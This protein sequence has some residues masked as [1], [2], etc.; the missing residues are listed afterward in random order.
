[1]QFYHLTAQEQV[2]WLNYMAFFVENMRKNN[3]LFVTIEKCSPLNL[4]AM[5]DATKKAPA[6]AGALGVTSVMQ[7]L[8]TRIDD[9]R[10]RVTTQPDNGSIIGRRIKEDRA[11]QCTTTRSV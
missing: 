11:I 8:R 7:K 10:S 4:R 9:T 3:I 1:M 6:E 2:N 5:T